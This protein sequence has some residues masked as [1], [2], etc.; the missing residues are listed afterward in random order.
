MSIDEKNKY[1]KYK[2]KYMDLKK[3]IKDNNIIDNNFYGLDELLCK[4]MKYYNLKYFFGVP[5]DLNMPLLDTMLKN[6]FEPIFVNNI[7]ELNASYMSEGYSRSKKLSLCI[8]GGIVG[9]LSA[10]NGFGNAISESNPV[11]LICGNNNLND[12]EK[13]KL[14]HHT[15]FE[16]NN[17][18][19]TIYNIFKQIVNSENST[20]ILSLDDSSINT[21]FDNLIKSLCNF[22]SYFLSIPVN[23]Q[24]KI[25]LHNNLI[26]NIKTKIIYEIDK[27]N[28]KINKIKLRNILK[29][30]LADKNILNPVILIGS[31]YKHLIKY[32]N[33]FIDE[34]FY[35]YIDEINASLFYTIE[36]KS[37]LDESK[38]CVKGCYWGGISKDNVLQTFN[39]AQNNGN[40]LY[41]GVILF[42][43][44]TA[45]YTQIFK[46]SIYCDCENI[47]FNDDIII[48]SRK[49]ILN[50][51]QND[52]SIVS[53][54][55]INSLQN[56]INK[57]DKNIDIF[58]ETG[59]SWFYAS[60][61]VF[62]SGYNFNI[63]M[64][65]GSIGWCFPSSIGYSLAEPNRKTICLS[66]DGAFNCVMQELATAVKLG[67]ENKINHI[68]ILIENKKYQIE[69]VLDKQNYN[70]LPIF[71]YKKI[72][73]GLGLNEQNIRVVKHNELEKTLNELYDK[74][75]GFYFVILQLDSNEINLKMNNWANLVSKYTTH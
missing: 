64:K 63:S 12:I 59:S 2:T 72:A 53:K 25:K 41:L 74:K 55:I 50:E 6:K 8:V 42:D 47:I 58:A 10:S 21:T 51:Y 27:F 36:A 54:N 69:N 5:S 56:L 68:L 71:N 49:K 11:L 29:N 26:K 18:Q 24:N 9:S 31:K 73:I 44:N 67:N 32:N 13:K 3:K 40:L 19:M 34:D 61:L 37:M 48:E 7:N 70:N 52:K 23:L 14:S 38:K 66:G 65:Y 1:Y 15:F 39:E 46:P 62:P 45:G 60:E 30:F 4:L 75:N 43:Y 33:N 17:D 22:K 28:N 57:N 35:T 20:N 16:N